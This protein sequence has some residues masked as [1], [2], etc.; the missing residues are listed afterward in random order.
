MWYFRSPEIVFGEDALNH[1]ETIQGER[2]FI[3]TDPMMVQLGFVDTVAAHLTD[4]GLAIAVFSDVEPEPSIQTISTG[5]EKMLAFEPDWIVGL[6]GGSAMDAAKAM[7]ALYENPGLNPED[8]NPF[9]PLRLR[10]KARLIVIPTT[11]GTGS[12]ATWATVLTDTEENRKLGT[13]SPEMV[14]D[15][16]IVDPALPAKMPPRLTADTGL[17]A[18]THAIEGYTCSL[19]N[20]FS[21]AV[22]L[23]GA[24]L[25][26]DYLP[27]AVKD[28]R[29]MEAREKMHNAATLAG[30]GFGNAMAALAHSLGHSLGAIFHVPHGRAVA[31]FLPYTIQFIQRGDVETRFYEISR[32][33]GLPAATPAEGAASLVDAIRQLS[34]DVGQPLTLK[35]TLGTGVSR[36]EFDAALD[37][38]IANAE[39]DSVIAMSDRIPSTDEVRLLF[40]YAY[41]G[42]AIDF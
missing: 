38:L 16:A 26:F 23:K 24:Q 17:D 30:L 14:A 36:A 21:D 29:D 33:L 10:R 1:L 2:A 11:S 22:C 12:E 4:A 34:R 27:R 15:I 20:D 9:E 35:D 8:I 18:L 3:V 13:G 37:T 41:D 31:L 28:G 19:R 6:G 40:E 5:A 32:F 25:V 39:A 7:W 42:K